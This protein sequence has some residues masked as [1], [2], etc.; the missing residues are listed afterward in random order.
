[1]AQFGGVSISLKSLLVND[2]PILVQSIQLY[3]AF[4]PV[5]LLHLIILNIALVP[6]VSVSLL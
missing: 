3:G 4:A 6:F 5:H 2:S 1:M